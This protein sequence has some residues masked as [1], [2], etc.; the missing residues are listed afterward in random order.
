M[1]IFPFSLA[2]TPYY[3]H[4]QFDTKKCYIEIHFRELKKK[5][6][7]FKGIGSFVPCK[8]P[9]IFLSTCS[10]PSAQSSAKFSGRVCCK[11]WFCEWLCV[12]C[13]ENPPCFLLLGNPIP[14]AL[15]EMRGG[16]KWW[17]SEEEWLWPSNRWSK[18]CHAVR[19]LP[20]RGFCLL[21]SPP[22]LLPA[23]GPLETS[24]WWLISGSCSSA[25]LQVHI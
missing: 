14:A 13:S 25:S 7:Y 11:Q 1:G 21:S 3:V 9:G 5:P 19:E 24:R 22:P 6:F 16:G 20:Q 18:F 2:V 4:G 17:D 10:F 12:L 15:E 8:L 23:P